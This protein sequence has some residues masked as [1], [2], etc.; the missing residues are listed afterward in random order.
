VESLGIR[1]LAPGCLWLLLLPLAAL[2]LGSRGGAVLALVT[3]TLESWRAAERNRPAQVQRKRRVPPALACLAAA[4]AC[5][6]LALARPERGAA[7]A[8]RRFTIVVDRSPSMDLVEGGRTRRERALE[9]VQAWIARERL[10]ADELERIEARAPEWSRYDRAD[11]LW[12]SDLFDALPSVAGFS[13]SGGGAVPGPIAREGAARLDWDGERVVR[14]ENAFAAGELGCSIDARLP[15]PLRELARLWAEGSGLAPGGS[16]LFAF[17]LEDAGAPHEV[18]LARDGWSAAARVAAPLAVAGGESTWLT[19][20]GPCVLAAPGKVRCSIVSLDEPAGDPAAFAVS[21]GGLFDSVLLD[22][23]GVVPLSE[24]TAR[25]APAWRAPV[26]GGTVPGRAER[27]L[28]GWCA[29]A[30]ALLA[31]GAWALRGIRA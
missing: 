23:P 3:G 4:L 25:G 6:A 22:P 8:G 13:A 19:A 31:L 15:E 21:W 7:A 18:G 12:V 27:P 17:E 26:G 14:V 2:W 29:L 30:A 28:G 20:G 10:G 24:R 16:P 5:A 1:F 9:P 11:A